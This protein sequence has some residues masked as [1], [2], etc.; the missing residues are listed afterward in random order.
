MKSM[1]GP[2]NRAIKHLDT[3]LG[4]SLNEYPKRPAQHSSSEV[5]H[6]TLPATELLKLVAINY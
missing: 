6:L 2:I 4:Q 5:Q 3:T 1:S